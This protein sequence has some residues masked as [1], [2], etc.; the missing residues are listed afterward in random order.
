MTREYRALVARG[1]DS[2]YVHDRLHEYDPLMSIAINRDA[3][4]QDRCSVQ[5]MPPRMEY[6][7]IGSKADFEVDF[8]IE[9]QSLEHA[10]SLIV[11][12]NSPLVS[13]SRSPRTLDLS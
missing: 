7:P 9:P 10:D 13:R 12:A 2:L 1:R 8:V 6:E 3:T 4:S 11:D 5:V